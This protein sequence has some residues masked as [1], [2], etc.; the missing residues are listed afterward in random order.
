MGAM[1]NAYKILAAKPEVKGPLVRRKRQWNCNIKTYINK[2]GG[3]FG[4]DLY[5]SG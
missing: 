1:L 2:G 4:L 5:A 3:G